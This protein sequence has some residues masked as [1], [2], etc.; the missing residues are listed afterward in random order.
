MPPISDEVHEAIARA[1]DLIATSQRHDGLLVVAGN[2]GSF[3]DALHIGGELAKDFERARPLPEPLRQRIAAVSGREDLGACL[4]QGLRVVVLGA[5]GALSSA[6]DNDFAV[7]HAGLAQELCSLGRT[8]DTLLAIS[9]SG[10]SANILNAGYVAR[11][12]EMHVVALT[13]AAPNRLADLADVAISAGG[14]TTAEVQAQHVVAYHE[15]CRLVERN[16]FA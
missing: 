3:A 13:G 16:L 7:R 9:T 5:N 8:G 6:I 2:G 1:A 15:L 14:T 10:A 11:A 12:L 4:Q